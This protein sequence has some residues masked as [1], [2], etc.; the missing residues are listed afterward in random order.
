MKDGPDDTDVALSHIRKELSGQNGL[1]YLLFLG[2]ET[3]AIKVVEELE[4]PE[5]Q[6]AVSA[7]PRHAV[8]ILADAKAQVYFALSK[9]GQKG[10]VKTIR[11]EGRDKIRTSDPEPYFRTYELLGFGLNRK[12]ENEK[13]SRIGRYLSLFPYV[14]AHRFAH[15][16]KTIRKMTWDDLLGEYTVFLFH[17]A[18]AS[19]KNLKGRKIR[20]EY[21][22]FMV[23]FL[24]SFSEDANVIRK[25]LA[26]PAYDYD[27]DPDAKLR[28]WVVGKLGDSSDEDKIGFLRDAFY[29]SVEVAP[30]AYE[31][32]PV[33]MGK[34]RS[35]EMKRFLG[36]SS[37]LRRSKRSIH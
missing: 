36:A 7:Q 21:A 11:Q 25:S 17:L 12:M 8:R 18:F 29:T 23:E 13:I 4:S 6:D 34:W 14:L 10:H 20:N 2:R 3:S 15:Y 19:A 24:N 33:W 16:G 30:K 35:E 26:L 27:K 1:V 28:P 5:M 32:M 37:S 31:T 9:L 22:R